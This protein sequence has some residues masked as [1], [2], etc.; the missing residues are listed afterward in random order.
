MNSGSPFLLEIRRMGSSFRPLGTRSS[1]MS[2]MNPHLYSR[3]A[4]SRIVSTVVLM[5]CSLRSAR[6]QCETGNKIP[7]GTFDGGHAQWMHEIGKSKPLESAA[8]DLVDDPLV[9]LS[10]AAALDFAKPGNF[11]AAIS[12]GDGAFE[13]GNYF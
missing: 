13:R 1:S 9:V 8:H 2:L 12:Q 3:S 4:R 7:V 6:S 10:R 11:G 5:V